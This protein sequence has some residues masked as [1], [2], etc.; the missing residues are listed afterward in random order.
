MG[1]VDGGTDIEILIRLFLCFCCKWF[2]ADLLPLV[3]I[4]LTKRQIGSK[5]VHLNG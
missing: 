4:V 3:K 1:T 5:P 2:Y